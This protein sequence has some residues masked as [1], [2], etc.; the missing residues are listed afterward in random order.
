M[1]EG[2]K[3]FLPVVRVDTGVFDGVARMDH[4][5]VAHIDTHMGDWPGAV[6]RPRVKRNPAQIK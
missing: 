5:T 3:V 1:P 2:V 4:H 6:I